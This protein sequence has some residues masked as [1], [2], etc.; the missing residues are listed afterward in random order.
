MNY[1]Y[2]FLI[3]LN[4]SSLFAFQEIASHS[5]HKGKRFRELIK[6][7]RH[8]RKL[9]KAADTAIPYTL[10]TY[11][12]HKRQFLPAYRLGPKY[13]Y[14]DLQWDINQAL[15]TTLA[16]TNITATDSASIIIGGVSAGA[17]LAALLSFNQQ[18]WTNLGLSTQLIKGFFGLA[19]ALD[20]SE[21]RKSIALN[22]Y[23]GSPSSVT[24]QLANPIN[25]IDPADHFPSLLL[26]GTK[27]GLTNY[28][29]CLS[30]VQQLEQHHCPYNFYSLQESTHL[31]TASSWYYDEQSNYG[32]EQILLDW[33]KKLK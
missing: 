9:K 13:C 33:L 3:L 24:F 25:Y 26:H 22:N 1:F 15:L 12:P 4:S 17:N 21:L 16:A 30:F 23:A 14:E 29:N 27:D 32:Q 6:T 11:G 10:L 8:L 7:P 5:T 31:E 20:L 18:R 19:G 2:L 28:Q